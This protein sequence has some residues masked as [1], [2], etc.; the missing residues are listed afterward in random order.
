[1]AADGGVFAFFDDADHNWLQAEDTVI[2]VVN[3]NQFG[4]IRWQWVRLSTTAVK[5]SLS[6]ICDSVTMK[7][8]LNDDD[9]SQASSGVAHSRPK[10]RLR[11]HRRRWWILLFVTVSFLI[12]KF[13]AW[14]IPRM[15]PAQ[16]EYPW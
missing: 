16:R 6:F 5:G 4:K 15:E 11:G 8:P 7:I 3:V 14:A 13:G 9:M 2:A 12:V 10:F 1:M